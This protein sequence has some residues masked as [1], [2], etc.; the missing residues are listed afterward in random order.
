M[1]VKANVQQ[2]DS[3]SEME[4]A[5]NAVDETLQ[6]KA[7]NTLGVYNVPSVILLGFNA[8]KCVSQ[9]FYIHEEAAKIVFPEA[10]RILDPA[11]RETLA[12]KYVPKAG[13]GIVAEKRGGA[14]PPREARGRI[15]RV[16]S[17]KRIKIPVPLVY[18]A[19]LRSYFGK[20]NRKTMTLIFPP[21]ASNICIAVWIATHC[22]V[23]KLDNF[24]HFWSASGIKNK[25]LPEYNTS[26]P[27]KL[28][29]LL[30][31]WGN[32]MKNRLDGAPVA[33]N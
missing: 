28:K 21:L 20:G 12:Y 1:G 9:E 29:E 11:S 25:I 32:K 26:D 23:A 16:F 4:A 13:G 22:E 14:T 5:L 17:G 31:S 2:N 7:K 6:G 27:G 15:G 19:S 33:P 30:G 24:T 18:R 10:N 8:D 3:P